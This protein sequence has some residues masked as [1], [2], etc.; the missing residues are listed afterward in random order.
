MSMSMKSA[1]SYRLHMR[2]FLPVA[3][4][5]AVAVVSMIIGVTAVQNNALSDLEEDVSSTLVES[6]EHMQ[7]GLMLAGESVS[8]SLSE[9]SQRIVEA[10]Q[11]STRQTLEQEMQ[12]L[13]ADLE[14]ILQHNASSIADLLASVAPSAILSNN[15]AA[16]NSYAHSAAQN[17]DIVFAFYLNE[18]GHPMTRFFDREHPLVLH[19]LSAADQGDRVAALLKASRTDDQVFIVE[20]KIETQGRYLGTALICVD[21]SAVNRKVEELAANMDTMVAS[22][23]QTI[24]EVL[25][26]EADGV[27]ATITGL[28]DDLHDQNVADSSAIENK[29]EN[30][31]SDILRQTSAAMTMIGAAAF[32]LVLV[33][34]YIIAS[35][36]AR[37]IK[38]ITS[39]AT[40][41]AQ[42]NQKLAEAAGA[43]AGGDL[44]VDVDVAAGDDLLGVDQEKYLRRNDEIGTLCVSFQNL[45]RQQA[46][47]VKAFLL[48]KT[49][50]HDVFSQVVEAAM[51][52]N[53]G[54]TQIAGASQSLSQGATESAA[55]LEQIGASMNEIGTQSKHNANNAQQANHLAA[56]ARNAVD[57]GSTRMDEM[58]AAMDQIKS[59][60]QHIA[61]IIKTIDE[62]AFQTNL[63]ALNAAVEAARA[64]RHGKGF[65]VVAEEVRSLAGRSAKAA[66]ETAELIESSNAR[67]EIGV[68]IAQQTAEALNEIVQGIIKAADLVAE[69]AAASNEQALGVAEVSKGLEQIDDVTQQN[70]AHAEETASA[71]EELLFQARDMQDMLTRFQLNETS[72]KAHMQNTALPG[73]ST[74]ASQESSGV[75]K[76]VEERR[77]VVEPGQEIPLDDPEFEKY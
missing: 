59:S 39:V 8:F 13:A 76:M 46:D 44:S 31:F 4:V 5:L 72:C 65:A 63:L 54:A 9:M 1:S 70:S 15:F 40:A 47:L 73:G 66:S 56:D 34:V 6:A 37:P 60:S 36:I 45:G 53:A 77:G 42:R 16:L 25:Q 21:R 48:M 52:V 64:G 12:R 41:F 58:V 28:V 20:R 57:R 50:M 11:E 62:I 17:P 19:L 35:G 69:I 3:V 68:A 7:T 71:A 30:S 32:V 51:Q 67:V 75:S 43:A 49:S 2:L 24:Q 18:H 27:T 10:L 33:L 23:S 55:S 26:R 29:L 22:S 74:P 61:K 38:S 14:E